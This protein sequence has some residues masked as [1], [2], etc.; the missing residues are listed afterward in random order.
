MPAQAQLRFLALDHSQ[1]LGPAQCPSLLDKT[2]RSIVNSPIF[3]CRSLI[4]S[5]RSRDPRADF[6]DNVPPRPAIACRFQLPTRFGW[7]R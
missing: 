5:S 2:C 6:S 4:S 1:A 7:I 3:A